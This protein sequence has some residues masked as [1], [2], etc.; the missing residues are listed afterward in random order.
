MRS[1]MKDVNSW[2]STEGR[3]SRLTAIR[4]ERLAVP[5]YL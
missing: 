2:N 4:Y 1:L 3:V 5:A